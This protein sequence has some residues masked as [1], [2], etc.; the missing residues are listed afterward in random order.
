MQA[1]QPFGGMVPDDGLNRVY[2]VH[3]ENLFIGH[4]NDSD[5]ELT[6]T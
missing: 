6:L 2:Q 4:S 3:I 5:I 1:L